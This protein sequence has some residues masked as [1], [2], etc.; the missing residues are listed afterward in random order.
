VTR[1]PF[2][3]RA[4][5]HQAIDFLLELDRCG[6]WA[7]MGMGKTVSTLTALDTLFLAGEP[8]PALV[9]APLRVAKS[10]WPAEAKKWAHLKDIE[11]RPILGSEAE[12]KLALRDSNANVFTINYE[13][14]PWL[15]ERV[16]PERWPFATVVADESTKLKG[17]RL[18]QGTQRARALGRVA[19]ARSKRFIELTGTPAPNGLI[20]LWGQAWFLD[21]GHR[22]GRTFD[23]F[24]LRWFQSIPGGDGYTQIKPLA[25]AQKEIE[26]RLR[27]ICLTLDP[28][29]HFDLREPIHT[30]IKVEL[31]TKVRG[32]YRDMEREL[33]M[34]IGGHDI[35]AFNAASR[36]M[37]CLQLCNGAVY[38]QADSGADVVPWLEVHDE[39]LQAL[40]DIIEEAAGM[41]VLVAYQ[42]KSDLARL[43]KAFP[44]G[45]FLDADPQTE[46]DWNA[47]KIPVLFA[48]PKSAGHGLN[49]QDGGNIIAFFGHW[50]DLELRQQI[51]ERIGPVRQAQSGYDRPVFIYDIVAADTVDELVIARHETKR[52]VQDLLLEAMKRKGIK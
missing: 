28:R 30:V 10:T 37:K 13:N 11:V 48:H 4:Y 2:A 26:A 1:K 47:G 19:H 29:D 51:I 18:K 52:E 40:E 27:D 15:L 36:T 41:P 31:P 49:L 5:Q 24:K 8:A 21:A 3:P 38:T 35:E 46:A 34:Q 43:L 17:F 20:D 9:I 12:R 45:R 50:W 16:T 6:L 22:L 42:F 25:H 23:S 32:L 14:L 44:R 33:F 7:G 39:K